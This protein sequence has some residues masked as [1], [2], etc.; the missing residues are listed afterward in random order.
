MNLFDLNKKV[1]LITGGNGGIGYAMAKAMGDAGAN[2]IIAGRNLDK[3][4]LSVNK[5]KNNNIEAMAIE[6]DVDDELS[7]QNMVNQV[8]DKFQKIDIL[9]N[10]AGTNIRKRPEEYSLKEWTSIINTNL[11][12][13]FICS[14]ACY[15][16]FITNKSGKIINIGSMHSLFGAPLGSAYSASKGGVVQLTKSFANTW[17][18]KNI[19]VNAVL[20]GYIDTELTKKARLDIPGLEQRVTERTPAG[21]WGDPDDLG[22]IAV[23][24]ASE[25]SNYITGTA[26]PVDGGYSI[27]G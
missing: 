25:A 26:I 22:G 9:V 1:A 10:N 24:L 15:K 12:S 19:Q 7:C 16:H 20:P 21:R 27:N 8:V 18:S 11:V 6:V 17:A 5:L 3:N 14:K 4:T 13:M 2:I 23:F